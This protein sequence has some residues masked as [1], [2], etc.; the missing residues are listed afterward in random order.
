MRVN[1]AHVF[2]CFMIG[3]MSTLAPILVHALTG[4][5]I[6]TLW[7]STTV[8]FFL[9]WLY[10][11]KRHYDISRGLASVATVY[12]LE[13]LAHLRERNEHFAHTLLGELGSLRD[14]AA[15]LE[16]KATSEMRASEEREEAH[17]AATSVLRKAESEVQ[18]I[19][20]KLELPPL[21]GH[22]KLPRGQA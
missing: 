10:A 2:I 18:G 22:T 17:R 13:R 19:L 3:V 11:T 5:H 6:T 12:R 16:Q 8:V 20:R 4:V 15:A 1:H 7:F 21:P 14:L 9:L